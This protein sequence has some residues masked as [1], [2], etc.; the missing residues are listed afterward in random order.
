M[1]NST[2]RYVIALGSN[3]RLP[4]IGG[5]RKMLAAARDAMPEAGI[6]VLASSRVCSSK[7]IGP[8][9][10]LYANSAVLTETRFDPPGLLVQLQE[11]EKDFGRERRG[12]RWRSR[13]LDLDIILWSG[14]WWS[15]PDLAIPHPLFRG[16]DFVTHPAAEVAPHWRDPDSG[17]TLRQISLRNGRSDDRWR[18]LSRRS[19][20]NHA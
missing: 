14:G 10:R 7:P 17:L 20:P 12:I 8:S 5:P 6:Q 4:R 2:H 13:S 1:A 9:R 19:R 3:M 11:I 15:S 18:L 16:R